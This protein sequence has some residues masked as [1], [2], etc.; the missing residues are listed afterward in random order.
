MTGT[1]KTAT[2]KHHPPQATDR[3]YGLRLQ[4]GIKAGPRSQSHQDLSFVKWVD[5]TS[6]IGL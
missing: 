1:P 5:N 4:T 6:A 2:D 3:A